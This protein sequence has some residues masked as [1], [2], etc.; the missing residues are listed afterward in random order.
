MSSNSDAYVFA[1]SMMNNVSDNKYKSKEWI[2]INDNSNGNYSSGQVV[3]DTSTLANSSTY[4]SW[5]EAFAVLPLIATLHQNDADGLERSDFALVMKAVSAGLISSI[6]IDQNGKT[7]VSQTPKLNVYNS[8]NSYVNNGQESKTT[9]EHLGLIPDDSKSWAYN[10]TY[11]RAQTTVKQRTGNGFVNNC[12]LQDYDA[13][14]LDYPSVNIGTLNNKGGVSRIMANNNS[15]ASTFGLLNESDLQRELRPYTRYAG[16]GTLPDTTLTRGNTNYQAWY[17]SPVIRLKDITNLFESLGLVKG[18]YF[19]M[20]INLNLGSCVVRSQATADSVYASF[21]GE[22]TFLN[23]CPIQVNTPEINF[24][25]PATGRQCVVSLFCG[26]VLSSISSVSP[27]TSALGIPNHPLQQCRLYVPQV[28]LSPDYELQ[29]VDKYRDLKKIEFDDIF[30][31]QINNIASGATFS[32]NVSNSL[33]GAYAMVLVPT[34]SSLVNGLATGNFPAILNGTASAGAITRSASAYLSPFT[35]NSPNP[36]SVG[37]F[38]VNLNGKSLFP[39]FLNYTVENF[40]ENLNSWRSM[41]GN[42]S[43]GLES[44]LIS[45]SDWEN[46]Y[47]YYLASWPLESANDIQSITISGINNSRVACDYDI[48]VVCRRTCKVNVLT[49][50][51]SESNF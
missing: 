14:L 29:L 31:T 28:V 49:G 7:M 19:R 32:Y 47:R 11:A 40:L 44:S 51:V 12:M 3:I 50:Q 43:D 16:A 48:F 20:T 37:S 30:Q 21:L 45:K 10:T 6:T 24:N 27:N 39:N 33:R 22:S 46:L 18:A 34:I 25:T 26:T 13:N 17:W 41:N 36:V 4:C 23:Y 42:V 1:K 2:Y 38:Q 15:I 9:K 5:E 35:S 8:F